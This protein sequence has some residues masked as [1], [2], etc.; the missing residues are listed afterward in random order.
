MIT[1]SPI[2]SRGGMAISLSPDE[3]RQRLTD[4]LTRVTG[5]PT[6]IEQI[7][8]LAGGA[9]RDMWLI[10]AV[11]DGKPE[12]LVLRRDLPT[13]MHE[14]ALSR[15]HEFTLMKAA[16]N[17]GI[18]IAHPRWV[19]EDSDVLG[20]PFFIMD[21]VYG[22][23]IGRKVVHLPELAQAR[24]ALPEQMAQQ[25]ADIH[26]LD[27]IE[28][29]LGFLPVPRAAHTPAQ[30]AIAQT[31]ET[32]DKLHC[33]NPVLFFGLRWA[34]AHA[35]S[36]SHT[37]FVHGD[38][39][40]GNIIVDENG[41]AAVADW[42][43]AHVGDPL[44]DLGYCCMRDWR[45]GVGHLRMGGIVAREP[46]IAA[47]ERYANVRVD[48]DAVT[49]WEFIGNLRWAAICL[50]QTHRHLSGHDP[51]VELASLGRRSAEMQYEM[52]KLI[53]QMGI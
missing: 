34:E 44:E 8:P 32:L 38:F 6:K 25:L 17:S 2:L 36:P 29:Q 22:V 41:L 10:D 37:T 51:S 43:F 5:A 18:K 48:R 24:N 27:M 45:F 23:A 50:A 49:F 42:E 16:H 20:M 7:S 33:T 26:R 53:E 47:Y 4:Y 52:L 13:T 39:R 9:S 21:F 14:G 40:I 28:H 19:C 31:Y 12:R 35:P 3:F 30:E 1:F 11:S 46:F 15:A